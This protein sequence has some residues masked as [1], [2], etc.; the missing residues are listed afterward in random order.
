M[1]PMAKVEWDQTEAFA[2]RLRAVREACGYSTMREFAKRLGVEEDA[3]G[4]Y[5]RARSLPHPYI[6]G[7]IR[8]LT[9]VT[10]DY[11]YYGDERGLPIE[12]LRLIEAIRAEG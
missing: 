11:L 2:K 10:A 6:I 7:R 1:T 12:L 5:E 8:Q 4:W 3:Y 9:G